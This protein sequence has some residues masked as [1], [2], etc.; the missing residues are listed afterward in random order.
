M[1]SDLSLK[2]KLGMLSDILKAKRYREAYQE[3][4]FQYMPIHWKVFYGC[5]KYRF[6]WGVYVLLMVIKRIIT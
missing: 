3:L 1:A 2:K 4:E 5:G 6:T